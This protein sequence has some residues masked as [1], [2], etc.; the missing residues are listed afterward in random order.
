MDGDCFVANAK[1]TCFDFNNL[2]HSLKARKIP[3]QNVVN[4]L[5]RRETFGKNN[6]TELISVR[7]FYQNV[8]PNYTVVNVEKPPCFLRKFSPDG[9]FLI[10]FSSDQTSVEIYKF[11]GSA[12]AGS[13][14][15]SCKGE[16]LSDGKGEESIRKN[17]FSTFLKLKSVV[18]MPQTVQRLNRECSLF[19]NCGR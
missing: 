16:H 13:L 15:K 7:Q 4:R 3:V 17:I 14:L 10:A 11:F 1:S 8:F 19:T 5:I 9:R 12:A 18:S 6:G 2:R